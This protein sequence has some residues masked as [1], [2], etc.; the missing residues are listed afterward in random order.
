MASSLLWL[1]CG[2]LAASS[3]LLSQS[4]EGTVV[5]SVTGLPVGGAGVSIEAGGKPVYQA[6]TDDQGVFRIQP[7]KAGTYT[8]SFRKSGFLPSAQGASSAK[9]DAGSSAIHLQGR[10][11]P[12]S[13]VAGRVFDG[14]GRPV[15]GAEL[16]LDGSL[17]GQ[18]ATS[19]AEGNY[20][21]RATPGSYI[22]SARSP[23][24]LRPPA[25][26]ED[27]RLGWAHTYYPSA[28]DRYA[29]VKILVPTGSDVW[30]LDITLRATR[31]VR[32][33]GIVFGDRGDPAAKVTVQAARTDETLSDEIRVV[34]KEDGSFEFPSLP[35]GEWRL[36]A[37]T[38][39]NNSKLRASAVLKVAGHELEWLDLRLMPP[40]DVTGRVAFLPPEGAKP[41]K[42]ALVIFLRP[43]VAGS[44]GLSQT[45]TDSNGNFKIENV[46]PGQYKVVAVSPGPPYFLNSVRMGNRELLGQYVDLVSGTVPV[47]IKFE[48]EGGGV[49]GMVNDCG[50][51]TVVLAPQDSALQEPQFVQTTRCGDQG[52][53]QIA[54][55]R[56]GDYY[57]FAFNQWGGAAELL[58][59]LDQSLI[60]KAVWVRV[61]R[62]EFGNVA[63]QITARSQ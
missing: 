10:L 25:A 24:G 26:A 30:G 39:G 15:S 50:S 1:L 51:A 4:I 6:T 3:T 60:N 47:E 62:G 43:S 7:V 59:G 54:N 41:D 33:G 45:T 36:F 38:E 34:S 52:Q 16:L 46:Y 19:D 44:E 18:T 53:F 49:R 17:T 58:S 20:L 14:G 11:T 2:L 40:F 5:D 63:L 37:E 57:A 35:E 28:L 23:I 22:L 9:F 32:V 61:E 29:A 48:S 42:K 12:L 8:A 55:V 27:E 31:L 56:P 13:R 21:F